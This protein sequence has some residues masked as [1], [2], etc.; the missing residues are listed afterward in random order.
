MNAEL[1]SA[2]K[3]RV[4]ELSGEGAEKISLKKVAKVAKSTAATFNKTWPNAKKAL[5][6]ASKIAKDP[7]LQV[8]IKTAIT[9]GD[10]LQKV[11]KKVDKPAAKPGK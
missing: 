2:L 7:K 8:A 11:T 5:V 1:E 10:G 9:I 3:A 6:V 4:A